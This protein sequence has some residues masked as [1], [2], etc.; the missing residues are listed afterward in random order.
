MTLILQYLWSMPVPMWDS[1]IC[2]SLRSTHRSAQQPS[3]IAL[4]PWR[5]TPSSYDHEYNAVAGGCC[6]D[7]HLD[8]IL[9]QLIRKSYCDLG[10]LETYLHSVQNTSIF[11][12]GPKFTDCFVFPVGTI[13]YQSNYVLCGYSVRQRIC[14]L[15]VFIYLMSFV[16]W[17]FITIHSMNI[18]LGHT[19][20]NR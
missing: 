18:V 3:A 10:C 14:K 16:V 17:S 1:C 19:I 6:A 7:G 12:V 13:H 11:Y 4:R 8:P 5:H 2:N 9:H 20:K 15:N